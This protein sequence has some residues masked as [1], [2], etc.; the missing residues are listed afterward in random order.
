MPTF[1][2]E[3]APLERSDRVH[4]GATTC[5]TDSI[6]VVHVDDDPE[7]ADITQSFLE[8]NSEDLIVESK[9]DPD[10]VVTQLRSGSLDADCIVSDYRM[11]GMDGLELLQIVREHEE[12]LPFVLFTGKGSEE[13]AAEAIAAGVTDYLQ[14][15]GTEKYSILSNRINNIVENHRQQQELDQIHKQYQSLM[16]NGSDIICISDTDGVIQYISP[17][18]K[19]ILG[20]DPGSL[21]GE[22]VFECMHPADRDRVTERFSELQSRDDTTKIQ[23]RYRCRKA[24]DEWRWLE[25]VITDG[26]DSAV[27]RFVINARDVTEQMERNQELQRQN[28]LFEAVEK[29][30]S[31]GGWEYDVRSETLYWSDEIRR[32]HGLP[33]DHEPTLDEAIGFY[34]PKDQSKIREAIGRA[35]TEGESFD[36]ELRLIRPDGEIRW[37][38]ARGEPRYDDEEIIGIRGTFQ[39]ITNRKEREKRLEESNEQLAQY[40]HIVETMDDAA[41]IIN[42]DRNIVYADNTALKQADLTTEQAQCSECGCSLT[43]DGQWRMETE[44]GLYCPVCYLGDI[45][46]D[47]NPLELRNLTHIRDVEALVYGAYG[48]PDLLESGQVSGEA[49]GAYVLWCSPP[50]KDTAGWDISIRLKNAIEQAINKNGLLYVGQSKNVPQRIMKH[51]AGFGSDLTEECPPRV[52]T[53]VVW[54]SNSQFDQ[55][56]TLETQLGKKVKT[57][58]EANGNDVACFWS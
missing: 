23:A 18:I 21:V 53:G 48:A 20:T 2:T 35:T 6:R 12:T 19:Q 26:Q 9:T 41:L 22:N 28:D 10:E 40:E 52:L 50:E 43:Q 51:L 17:S 8:Q 16:E 46:P 49:P 29:L 56:H 37:T 33:L 36:A 14:K 1:D 57:V 4:I 32:I 30:A 3:P 24:V 42:Q 27:G 13:I 25:A 58:I 39:D 38:R 45:F 54:L 7:F 15:G 34:H 44:I 55:L 5:E 31:V 11:P 47:A